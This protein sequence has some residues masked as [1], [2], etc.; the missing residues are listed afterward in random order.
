MSRL[1]VILLFASF[2]TP[3]CVLGA[4]EA[5]GCHLDGDCERGWV[6]RAGACLRYSTDAG[7]PN[8]PTDA[9][10]EAAPDDASAD[11]SRD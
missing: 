7:P 2:A 6:C 10:A 5:P 4:E 8:H 11:A 9:R 3:G 1:A